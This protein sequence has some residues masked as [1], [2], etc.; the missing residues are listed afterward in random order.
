MSSK[1]LSR[2]SS[3][4]LEAEPTMRSALATSFKSVLATSASQKM[5]TP[6][7]TTCRKDQPLSATTTQA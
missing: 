3:A 6:P 1:I 5:F 2:L 7:R 4:L